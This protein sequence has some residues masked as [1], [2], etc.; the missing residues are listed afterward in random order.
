MPA[1]HWALIIISALISYPLWT[2]LHEAS[3]VLVASQM[4]PLKWVRW[5]LY[6]HRDEDGNFFFA[7]VQWLWDSQP[8]DDKWQWAALYSAPRVMNSV[9]SLV[10][11]FSFL[12]ES[13]WCF[14]WMI[15]WGAGL[16]D[17]S[18]GSV[19]LREYSDLCRTA[20]ALELNPWVLRAAGLTSVA[21]SAA[22]GLFL[23]IMS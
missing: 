8:K 14:I 22:L 11:P 6:P 5:W 2:F 18:V 13:P 10:F 17:F 4:A 9:A 20:T 7:K 19:G 3:H 12:F 21:L 23:T 16:I 15:V 1:W